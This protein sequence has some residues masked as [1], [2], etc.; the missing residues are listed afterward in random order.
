MTHAQ[1]IVAGEKVIVTLRHRVIDGVWKAGEEIPSRRDLAE[2][3]GVSP[4]TVHHALQRLTAEG[5]LSSE[6]RRLSRVVAYSPHVRDVAMVF[7]RH[8]DDGV[9]GGWSHFWT[10][11]LQ[12]AARVEKATARWRFRPFF[13]VSPHVDNAA[14]R[15][16]H[17]LV[18]EQRLGGI[19]TP[20]IGTVSPLKPGDVL[21]QVPRVYM[22]QESLAELADGASWVALD[23]SS[24]LEQALAECARAGRKKVALLTG[25]G[26][27]TLTTASIHGPNVRGLLLDAVLKHGVLCKPAWIQVCDPRSAEG[28]CGVAELLFAQDQH[29]RP[30]ALVVADDHAVGPAI[31]GL[32]SAGCRVPD[33]VLV[34]AHAS[35]P[36][37]PETPVP[38]RCVGF[39]V[40]TALATVLKLIAASQ[41]AP[42]RHPES[43]LVPART[44]QKAP[45]LLKANRRK[46]GAGGHD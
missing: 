40:D 18:R 19:F 39:D 6:V 14:W 4:V 38:V 9:A 32:L 2:E 17:K 22:L 13:N 35:F 26:G 28:V 42:G 33:D 29:D 8:P 34:V 16:L 37:V 12:A 44:D 10:A 15:E 36:K 5:F 23:G 21:R 31:A 25:G 11:L 30:D 24:L 45:S 41:A 20:D 27:G 43:V 46:S 1:S 3:L 7:V